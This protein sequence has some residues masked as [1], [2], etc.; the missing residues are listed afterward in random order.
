MANLC[1]MNAL[2]ANHTMLNTMLNALI[3]LYAACCM[4]PTGSF[5]EKLQV[6]CPEYNEASPQQSIHSDLRN[7]T[8]QIL[9]E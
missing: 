4:D 1:A 5:S 7:R 2:T 3:T 8:N 9:E 6:K